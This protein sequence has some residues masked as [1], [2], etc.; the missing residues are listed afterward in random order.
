MK[1]IFVHG[2]GQVATSWDDTI[3]NLDVKSKCVCPDLVTLLADKEVNYANL[4]KAFSAYCDN[5]SEPLHICG[6]SLGGILA[7][8]YG[9][10]NPEKLSSLVL[11]GT[12]Y[13]MPVGLLKFQNAIFRFMPK[14]MFTQ[15]GFGKKDF[16]ELSKSM[17]VLDFSENLDKLS[18]PVLIMCG[19]KDNA[20]RKAAEELSQRLHS[21]EMQIVEK[22]GHEVNV[23]AP[24]TLAKL[25]N[26]FYKR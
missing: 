2:L 6:L 16:I 8:N 20:N 1:Y 23:D 18:C 5:F 9:I 25:L 12:Q 7:L 26:V 11:A 14:S 3:K 22:A 4:Y 17:M 24:E 15:M 19:E 10:D 21:A 13:K